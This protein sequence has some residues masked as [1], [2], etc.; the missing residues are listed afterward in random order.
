VSRLQE[1]QE[2][3]AYECRLTPDRA[4][5]SLDDAVE[6]L[7]DRGLL[8]WAPGSSLPSLYEALHEDPATPER[9]WWLEALA[10]RDGVHLLPIH[11]GKPLLVSDEVAAIVDPVLR[12]E[13][14]RMSAV[15]DWGELL[16]VLAANGPTTSEEARRR[17]GLK[18]HE[19]AQLVYPLERCGAVVSRAVVF[20]GAGGGEVRETEL[21]RWDQVFTGAPGSGGLDD[22]VVAG[23]RA[24]VLTPERQIRRWFSWPR[25]F[26]PDLTSR[27]VAEGRL[28]RPEPGWVALPD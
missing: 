9:R 6:F 4:L 19:F 23:V 17:F 27:L 11:R 21:A 26:S 24:A 12:A 16:Q 5:G 20:E 18:R 25:R 22:V 14:E 10:E 8:T 13:I 2:R 7:R 3:R 15:P 1:L 28:E